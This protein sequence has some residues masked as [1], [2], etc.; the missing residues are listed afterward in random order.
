MA[1]EIMA[2]VSVSQQ[3]LR[4]QE[5]DAPALLLNGELSP[6]TATER[7]R[8]GAGTAVV[9]MTIVWEA[10][11]PVSVAWGLVAPL[12]F[13]WFM[14]DRPIMNPVTVGLLIILPYKFCPGAALRWV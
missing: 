2:P 4:A 6:A 5:A 3:P 11:V 9:F 1:K 8:A 14:Y 13:Q 7:K 10:I 12:A